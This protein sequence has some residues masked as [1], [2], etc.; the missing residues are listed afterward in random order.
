VDPGNARDLADAII[1]LSENLQS[2]DR[3][4]IRK[5]AE[6]RF[7][8]TAFLN[9]ITLVYNSILNTGKTEGKVPVAK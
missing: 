2:F 5:Y 7:G 3:T 8:H 6:E 9:N 4:A 1:Y